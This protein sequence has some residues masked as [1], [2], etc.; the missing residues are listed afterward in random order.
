LQRVLTDFNADAPFGRVVDKLREHYGIAMPSSSA[1]IITL[2]HSAALTEK[3]ILPVHK[4]KVAHLRLISQVDGSMVPIV[5]PVAPGAEPP[6]NDEGEPRKKNRDWKEVR[7]N[8]TR[9]EGQSEPVF[10]VTTG[11]SCEAGVMMGAVAHAV[12]ISAVTKVHSVGDGAR[13]IA[14]ECAKQFGSRGTFLLDL[15]HVCE[16]LADAS[17]VC[18]PEDPAAWAAVQVKRLKEGDASSVLAELNAKANHGKRDE[19][20]PVFDCLRYLSNRSGHLDYPSAIAQGLP[21][22]SGEIE[23]ANKYIVQARLKIAGAWWSMKNATSML[24]LRVLRGNHLWDT[25]WERQA[26]AA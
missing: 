8:T 17:K 12:G 11:D 18:A 10:G 5:S 19:P 25:Y 23:S 20:D 14:Q 22:G 24:N 3:D 15:Y 7:L 4:G 21:I 9:P 16:Y 1:R 26:K 6:L 2:R 13:W